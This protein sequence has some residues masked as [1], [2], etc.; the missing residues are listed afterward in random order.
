MTHDICTSRR[1]ASQRADSMYFERAAGVLIDNTLGGGFPG[2]LGGTYLNILDSSNVLV[3][4][5]QTES[6]TNSLVYNEINHPQAGDY[7][8][9]ITFLNSAFSNPIIFNARRTFVSTGNSYG[10][11][12]FKADS[13]LL[14][15]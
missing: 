6:M 12:T 2:S 11:N 14:V 10:A 5:S 13:R 7:S 15:Y 8:A 1:T 9:P 3:S 4:H